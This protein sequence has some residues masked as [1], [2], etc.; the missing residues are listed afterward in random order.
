MKNLFSGT[1][2][3]DCQLKSIPIQLLTLINMLID[4]SACT[5]VSQ[6]SSSIAQVMF[7]GFKQA[8]GCNATGFCRDNIDHETPLKIYESLKMILNAKSKKLVEMVTA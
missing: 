2:D 1:S 4:G 3:T 8:P 6:A 5:T 7:S